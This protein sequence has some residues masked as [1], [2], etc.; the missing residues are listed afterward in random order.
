MNFINIAVLIAL[1]GLGI[2]SYGIIKSDSPN[3]I[4]SIE[5]SLEKEIFFKKDSLDINDTVQIIPKISDANLIKTE[6]KDEKINFFDEEISKRKKEL[7]GLSGQRLALN[8]EIET[9]MNKKKLLQ[10]KVS[11][12]ELEIANLRKNQKENL[13]LK[14]K[15]EQE[16]IQGKNSND[17]TELLKEKDELISRIRLKDNEIV[18]LKEKLSNFKTVKVSE[19][20]E[21]KET[22]TTDSL[23]S[24]T[25]E[26]EELRG[27]IKTNAANQLVSDKLLESQR[28]E[29]LQMRSANLELQ[30]KLEALESIESNLSNYNGIIATF[31]GNLLYE[32]KEKKIILVTL[33]GTKFTIL[34]DEF[35]GDLVAKCGLPVSSNS[36]DRC[37]ATIIAEMVVKD[38]NLILKGKEIKKITKK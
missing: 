23:N 32:P 36:K 34:Q 38:D 19:Q 35:P 28:S 10:G 18:D 13:K 29:L 27:K 8:A 33:E 14:N 20:A 2:F 37:F 4:V 7:D 25:L 3:K 17:I 9:L 5:N 1:I 21:S 30:K 31:T 15:R 6:K 24:L 11:D 26:L 12:F 22:E 16:E